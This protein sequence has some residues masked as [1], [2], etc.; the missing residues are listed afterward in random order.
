MLLQVPIFE[1]F[2]KLLWTPWNISYLF[3]A[4]S[5]AELPTGVKKTEG[6]SGASKNVRASILKCY[7]FL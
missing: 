6:D 1:V 5:H 4:S 2:E 7:C 3:R